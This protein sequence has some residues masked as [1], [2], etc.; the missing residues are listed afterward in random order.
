M[1]NGKKLSTTPF[2][3]ATKKATNSTNGQIT[4]VRSMGNILYQELS[5][6]IVGAAMEVHQVLGPGFLEAVY[7]EA[8]AHEFDLRK[9]AYERQFPLPVVY[10]G[11]KVGK[12]RPDF[13]VNKAIILEIKALSTLAS[14]HEAKALHYLAAT[15]LRLAILVNFGRTALQTKRLIR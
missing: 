11:I 7:E 1:S 13:V 2:S 10:K 15:G 9:I 3:K 8:L 12:Y 4:L 5:Y 6:L 14:E